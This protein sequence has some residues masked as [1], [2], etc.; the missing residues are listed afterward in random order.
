M[1]AGVFYS[2]T[3][4]AI[5]VYPVLS[6]LHGHPLAVAEMTEEEALEFAASVIMAVQRKLQHDREEAALVQPSDLS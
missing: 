4:R 5:R 2:R 1:P 3:A 6:Y